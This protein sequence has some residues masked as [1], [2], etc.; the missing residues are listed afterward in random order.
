MRERKKLLRFNVGEKLKA[1]VGGRIMKVHTGRK[2]AIAGG[3][4]L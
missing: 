4:Y 1:H 2:I 3:T